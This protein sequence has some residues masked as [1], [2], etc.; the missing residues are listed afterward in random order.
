[1]TSCGPYSEATLTYDSSRNQI[2]G[3]VP[4]PE[5]VLDALRVFFPKSFDLVTRAGLTRLYNACLEEYDITFF[6]TNRHSENLSI[7]DAYK[8]CKSFTIGKKIGLNS[9]RQSK[10]MVMNT[11][12]PDVNLL[13]ENH[14]HCTFVNKLKIV[15]FLVCKNGVVYVLE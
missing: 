4:I 15:G 2:V 5:S 7:L 9:L 12:L 1:M 10:S 3:S 6:I 11:L 8:T 13:V 14:E